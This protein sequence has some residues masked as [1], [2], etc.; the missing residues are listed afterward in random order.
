MTTDVVPILRV[1]DAAAAAA[2]YRRLGFEQVFEHRFEPELP[3]YMG[4]RREGAQIH[5]SEHTGDAPPHGLVYIWV[6]DVDEIAAEFG[7]A[8]DDQ[9][10][11]RE[12][13]LVDPDGNRLRVAQP[14]GGA[15]A[16]DL[17]GDGSTAQL[18]EL[19]RAMWTDATRSDPAWMDEHLTDTFT[20]FG[21][22]GRAYRRDDILDE[23]IGPI[24]VDLTG[25][26]A[27]AV[28]GDAALVTYR[29]IEGRGVGNRSSLWVRHRGRWL[30]E[31]HQGTP[32][33][34]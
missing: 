27:R 1:S 7:V 10:W 32:A 30:L 34:G 5:L 14:A 3:A 31:F 15:S 9:P 29:S 21:W 20:E 18:I 22:S 28:G 6:D 24:E 23:E 33:P 11:A 17:L 25:V 12:V 26:E 16:D 13:Q 19:E 8:V 4:L 2:W